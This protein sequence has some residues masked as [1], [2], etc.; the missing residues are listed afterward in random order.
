MPFVQLTHTHID[1]ITFRDDMHWDSACTACVSVYSSILEVRKG[2]VILHMEES[3]AKEMYRC[4]PTPHFQKI[5]SQFLPENVFR[6]ELVEEDITRIVREGQADAYVIAPMFTKRIWRGF[7][8]LAALIDCATNDY[9]PQRFATLDD[10]SFPVSIPRFPYYELASPF[11]V[12]HLTYLNMPNPLAIQF[13]SQD[14]AKAFWRSARADLLAYAKWTARRVDIGTRKGT[15]ALCNW[16][17]FFGLSQ[18][19]YLSLVAPEAILRAGPA[20]EDAFAVELSRQHA[21]DIT[22]LRVSAVTASYAYYGSRHS[23]HS[24]R[25]YYPVPAQVTVH[26]EDLLSLISEDVETVYRLLS[27]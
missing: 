18:N 7:K 25:W 15:L 17:A 3:P 2:Q 13:T 22:A 19:E 8:A 9:R 11:R 23:F 27:Q 5:W 4:M 20:P 1:V 10:P 14:N 12:P 24:P 21:S 16:G 6:H 26:D